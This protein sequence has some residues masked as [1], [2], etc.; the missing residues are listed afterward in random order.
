LVLSQCWIKRK[1]EVGHVREKVEEV[2]GT[3]GNL[4]KRAINKQLY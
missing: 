4:K 2:K 3:H 1:R